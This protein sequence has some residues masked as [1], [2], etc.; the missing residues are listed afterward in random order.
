ML[1]TLRGTPFLYQGEEIGMADGPIPPE[2]VV[3]VA[4]RDPERTP[5]QWD[6]TRNG[7]FTTG[8]PWLPVNPETASVNVASQHGDPDSMLGLYRTL[9]R[10]RRSSPALRRGS[11]RSV[12]GA[13]DDVFAY[14]RE[15]GSK[16]W[17]VALNFSDETRHVD[18]SHAFSG[19]TEL[20]LCRSTDPGRTSAD[21]RLTPTFELRP[22]EGLLIEVRADRTTPR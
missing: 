14:V 1:L 17:L 7:G 3:D 12:A 16:R 9:I 10:V 5:M 22:D 21:R 19:S 20:L 18:V 6:A 2:R 4:G 11:Y 8:D 15:L 13:P